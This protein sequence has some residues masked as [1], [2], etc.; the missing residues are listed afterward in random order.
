M[1]EWGNN[2]QPLALPPPKPPRPSP[3]LPLL[4]PSQRQIPPSS[5][6]PAPARP[7][8]ERDLKQHALHGE[9]EARLGQQRGAVTRA[10]PVE[11]LEE[12][13]R[14]HNEGDV[15]REAGGGARAVDGEDLV[16]VGGERGEDQAV[17]RRW[18][19][20]GWGGR[21]GEGKGGERTRW[22]RSRRSGA[23]GGPWLWGMGWRKRGRGSA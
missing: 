6:A 5:A 20:V 12:G 19:L 13:G 1:H 17:G 14:Q 7:V 10:G 11:D 22:G 23:R 8:V 18:G 21:G 3:T 2:S 9:H 4:P 15:E 16:R